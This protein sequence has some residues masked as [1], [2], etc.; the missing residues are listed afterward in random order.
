MPEF[1][2]EE[3]GT[4]TGVIAR[5]FRRSFFSSFSLDLEDG[6]E[7]EEVEP[8]ELLFLSPS[9]GLRFELE[10]G[11]GLPEGGA[12]PETECAAGRETVEGGWGEDGKGEGR[13]IE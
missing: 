2:L 9:G 13:I 3:E 1:G 8:L 5:D 12:F 11:L 10:G 6:A 4:S 7:L